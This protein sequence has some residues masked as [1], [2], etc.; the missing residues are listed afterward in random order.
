M[1][2]PVLPKVYV[3]Y[4]NPEWYEPVQKA[5]NARTIPNEGWNLAEGQVDINSFPPAGVYFNKMSASSHTRGNLHAKH[6]AAAVLNWLEAHDRRVVNNNRVLQLEMSK[7]A[8][9]V[10]LQKHQLQTPKTIVTQGKSAL[11]EAAQAFSPKPFIVK[12]NQGGKGLG[13][14]LFNN[15]AELEDYLSLVELQDWTVDGILLVQQYIPPHQERVIRME[16]I[17]GKFF[18][19]VQ[20][21]TGGGFELCPADA[22]EIDPQNPGKAIPSFQILSDFYIPEIQQC[23]AFLAAN[24]IE[25][26][27]IEFLQDAKG[28]KYFY[29]V[30]TNTNY[31]TEAE[32]KLPGQKPGMEAVVDFLEKAWNK[33]T[34]NDAPKV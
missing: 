2:R 1:N 18:Y 19:A 14:S 30:N 3:L 24:H 4:E 27:G 20:V 29:D 6:L 23:E 12:P 13:V 26:A 21:D 25:I 11:L 33:I 9:Q 28:N 15:V 7:A 5:L 31:N 17:G 22:C 32:D 8:Q 34:T 16:F 10:A